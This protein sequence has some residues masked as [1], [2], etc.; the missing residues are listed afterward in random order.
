MS[1]NFSDTVAA[2][3]ALKVGQVG[4]AP[5]HEMNN[6]DYSSSAW[7]TTHMKGW[8]PQSQANVTSATGMSLSPFI[9]RFT[10]TFT[11]IG[12]WHNSAA[13]NGQ[14]IR[15]GIYG[16]TNGIPSG[17]P[18]VD[19]G[20][21]AT[22]A[23]VA[24]RSATISQ[25]LIAGQVYYLAMSGS[26]ALTGSCWLVQATQDMQWWG[27][28]GVIDPATAFGASSVG[29]WGAGY[30]QAHVFGALPTIGTL[31][32]GQGGFVNSPLIMLKG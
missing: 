26:S 32:D 17:A 16:S 22:T 9:P 15:L 13:Q 6:T 8:T 28:F 31:I 4:A 7:Y 11:G 18:L 1:K 5:Y 21:I 12:W 25:K 30:T 27:G 24:F 3:K 23:A 2:I 14:N 29:S 10:H 20:N 19:T